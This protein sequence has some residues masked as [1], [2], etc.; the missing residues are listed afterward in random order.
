MQY[1]VNY[2]GPKN[3]NFVV[4]TGTGGNPDCVK[5]GKNI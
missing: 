5:L 3:L 4:V 2:A 1:C